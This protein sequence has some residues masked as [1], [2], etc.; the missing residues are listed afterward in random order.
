MLEASILDILQGNGQ[1]VGS[2]LASVT[3]FPT[4]T[5]EILQILI[6]L[7]YYDDHL[8]WKANDLGTL[9]FK[10]AYQYLHPLLPPY[11]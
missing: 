9:T 2:P 4:L 7:F 1:F 5:N 3:R 6:P 10:E 11:L 8:V